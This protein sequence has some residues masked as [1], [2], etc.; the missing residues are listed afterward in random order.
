MADITPKELRKLSDG[1]V[2]AYTEALA[3]R[4]DMVA[5]WGGEQP[6]HYEPPKPLGLKIV[7]ED[8][9]PP[10]E[11]GNMFDLPPK[12]GDEGRIE[13]LTQ[14]T[15]EMLRRGDANDLTGQGVP[16]I[17]RLESL[18]GLSDVTSRERNEAFKSAKKS[19]D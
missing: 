11:E 14:K 2:F 19:L 9:E 13:L 4:S 15:V 16:R 6:E 12:L 17:P 10:K 3:K 8:V 1:R 5:V 18:S 7:E